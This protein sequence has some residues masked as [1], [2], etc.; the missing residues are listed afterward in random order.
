MEK[1]SVYWHVS[2]K[3]Y[4]ADLQMCFGRY[5]DY[6]GAPAMVLLVRDGAVGPCALIQSLSQHR[7][8]LQEIDKTGFD[9]DVSIVIGLFSSGQETE[10]GELDELY[11]QQG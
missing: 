5:P 9:F 2:N 4:E 1:E 8:T 10:F 7:Q 6:K 11:A 3:Y